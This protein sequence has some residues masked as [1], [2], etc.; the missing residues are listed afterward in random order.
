MITRKLKIEYCDDFNFIKDK[1]K[2]YS[3]AIRLMC[4]MID[5]SVDSNFITKFKE[6]FELTDIE[7]RSLVADAKAKITS[8]ETSNGNKKKK[9]EELKKRLLDTKDLT[10]KERYTIFNKIAFLNRSISNNLVFGGRN[11]L[12]KITREYNKKSNKDE[13]LLKEYLAEYRNKRNGIPCFITGEANQK[14]N[15]FFDFSHLDDGKV[16]YKPFKGRI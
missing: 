2:N 16:I 9:I 5:E 13:K 14:G 6:R 1:V 10:K 12:Q 4:K 15:R 11:L 3:C 7:Y 8:L